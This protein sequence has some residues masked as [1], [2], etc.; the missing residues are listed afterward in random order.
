MSISR[1]KRPLLSASA[2]DF[3]LNNIPPHPTLCKAEVLPGLWGTRDQI[4]VQQAFTL[5][6]RQYIR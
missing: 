1:F 3:T 5:L 6:H 4:P 2:G